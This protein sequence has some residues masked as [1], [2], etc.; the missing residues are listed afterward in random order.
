MFKTKKITIGRSDFALLFSVLALTVFGLFMIYDASSYVAFRDFADKYRYAK[1]QMF[2][3][4]IGLSA[5]S[6]VS[7]FDYHRYYNL[8]LPILLGS[9]FLLFLVFIP[10]LGIEALGAKRWINLGFFVLQPSEFVKLALT[11][12]LSA[13]FSTREKG[14]FFAFLLLIGLVIFLVMLQPDMGTA[15]IILGQALILY[16]LSGGNI[17]HILSLIPAIGL[18]GLALILLE[19]YR[20]ARLA[21]FLNPGGDLQAS[22]YHLRQILIAL[23]SGGLF[24]VGVG[25]S[26]QKYAYLPEATTDS[27]FAIIAEEIGFFGVLILIAVI[28]FVIYRGFY[29]SLRAKDTFGKLL[30]GGITSFIAIQTIVNLGAQTALLPLTGVPLPFIS[31]GGS[32]L[33]INLISVGILLN[34]SRQSHKI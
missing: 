34:I 33:I 17:L 32:A 1:D 11:I 10:G 3:V 7:F 4:I 5:L 9:I 12:Y 16:F 27:I 28:L 22:S 14:R 6:L 23:G 2:W 30:A 31:Y 21:T 15:F 8:A 18:G 13:W 26:L 19:P 29:I 25:N 24:G 20:A